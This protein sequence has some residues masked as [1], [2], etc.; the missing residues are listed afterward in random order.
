[1]LIAFSVDF[2]KFVYCFDFALEVYT[3]NAQKTVVYYFCYIVFIP[4]SLY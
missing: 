4:P 3:W 1:L 2:S